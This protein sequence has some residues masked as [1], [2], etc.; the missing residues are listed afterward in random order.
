M[1]PPIIILFSSACVS[2][3]FILNLIIM[4]P[5]ILFLSILLSTVMSDDEWGKPNVGTGI[6]GG[7]ALTM[8]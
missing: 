3:I 6:V 8:D 4:N 5:V 2:L 1:I 7:P